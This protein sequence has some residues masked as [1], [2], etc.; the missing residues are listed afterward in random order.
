[1][2]DD[3]SVECFDLL[4]LGRLHSL[5]YLATPSIYFCLGHLGVPRPYSRGNSGKGVVL[6]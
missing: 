6:I 4:L 3:I 1:M 5:L 2:P